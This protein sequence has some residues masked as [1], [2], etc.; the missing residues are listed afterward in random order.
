LMYKFTRSKMYIPSIINALAHQL[1]K[2]P[3]RLIVHL[4]LGL[5]HHNADDFFLRIGK[6]LGVEITAPFKSAIMAK[7][8][9]L[10]LESW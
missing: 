5:F 10:L 2:F 9:F 7:I 8:T 3:A 6:I 1:A 4:S